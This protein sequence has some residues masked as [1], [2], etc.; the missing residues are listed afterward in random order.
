MIEQMKFIP[1]NVSTDAVLRNGRPMI[2]RVFD[3]NKNKSALQRSS[4][5]GTTSSKTGSVFALLV[6]V[7]VLL[8]A[9]FAVLV[10]RPALFLTSGGTDAPAI[11][12]LTLSS[13][14]GLKSLQ[15]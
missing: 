14:T 6:V 3:E 12:T 15:P 10:A 11:A 1:L 9:F 13:V 7:G 5:V 2:E 8:L 4:A